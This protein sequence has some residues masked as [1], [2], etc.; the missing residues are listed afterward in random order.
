MEKLLNVVE[1]PEDSA[2]IILIH[3]GPC[4]GK[5]AFATRFGY[6]MLNNGY[7]YIIWMDLREGYL[8]SDDINGPPSEEKL[9]I[10]ILDEF[11]M[12]CPDKAG[13]AKKQLKSK[14]RSIKENGKRV[15]V[16][17]DNADVLIENQRPETSQDAY[18][19]IKEIAS[20]STKFVLTSRSSNVM[21]VT[22]VEIKNLTDEES[23]MYVD[24]SLSKETL[25]DRDTL[26]QR[27]TKYSK[28]MPFAL[29]IL[30]YEVKSA[31]DRDYLEEYLDDV[32]RQPLQTLDDQVHPIMRLFETS[33]KHLTNEELQ[34]MK[35]LAVFPGSFSY[36]YVQKLSQHFGSKATIIKN[37]RQKGLLESYNENF[38]IHPLLQEFSRKFFRWN[39]EKKEEKDE[40]Q[41]GFIKVYVESLFLLGWESLEKD[42]F[43][44]CLTE[45]RKEKNNFLYL[46]E[47]LKQDWIMKKEWEIFN[48][49]S[50]DYI[51][52]M[53]FIA[54]LMYAHTL[55]NFFKSCEILASKEY[56]Y[57]A[58]SCQFE[59]CK[60][61]LETSIKKNDEFDNVDLDVD[62]Y[63]S[64]LLER[65][66]LADE[67]HLKRSSK[68]QNYLIGQL[69]GFVDK[70]KQ[71]PNKKIAS[72]FQHKACKLLGNIHK[73][74]SKKNEA[75]YFFEEAL[76]ICNN[77]V[78]Q[79]IH[80][81]DC[82]IQLA[83]FHWRFNEYGKANE[84]FD[85]AND[86]A[87]K[88]KISDSKIYSSY[89]L[90]HGR[91]LIDS[92]KPENVEKGVILLKK[93]LKSCDNT[94][95]MF[96]C[97]A[98]EYLLR[99][100]SRHS[101]KV[102]PYLYTLESPGF[103]ILQLV[104]KCFENDAKEL[105]KASCFVAKVYERNPRWCPESFHQLKALLT[106]NQLSKK[107]LGDTVA[108]ADHDET[109]LA[110]F[111]EKALNLCGEER[112][113][114]L[115][116][117]CQFYPR[118]Y[119][120]VLPELKSKEQVDDQL[121]TIVTD[122][123]VFENG[124]PEREFDEEKVE[125]M[126]R[127]SIKDMREAINYVQDIYVNSPENTNRN[128]VQPLF[129]WNKLLA[130][131]TTHI[132]LEIRER[133]KYAEAALIWKRHGA[134]EMKQR[135]LKQLEELA[136]DIRSVSSQREKRLQRL[137]A[138]EN[139]LRRMSKNMIKRGQR[140]ELENRFLK[141]F[142]DSGGFIDIRLRII[143][144][145]LN[146]LKVA[147]EKY[148]QYF[149]KL[150]QVIESANEG[151][152]E[153]HYKILVDHLP[154]LFSRSA[155]DGNHR[156]PGAEIGQKALTLL[157]IRKNT[158][159]GNYK[160]DRLKFEIMYIMA[161]QAEGKMDVEERKRIA[162]SAF[163]LF[164]SRKK[165]ERMTEKHNELRHFIDTL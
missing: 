53:L 133:A 100:D 88:I 128:L 150:L 27:I 35:V 65:R 32:E 72:Y 87:E 147:V 114:I 80:T 117:L 144:Y 15:L 13:Q 6:E 153:W 9:A 22:K 47:L 25:M 31:D 101:D 108:E 94:H 135:E 39:K 126:T 82:Y 142:E 102:I 61:L 158:L 20:P 162:L 157:E 119:D 121:L 97:R 57:R 41:A 73:K 14:F 34:L 43:A 156:H 141:L 155:F 77:S 18:R 116:L 123:F 42:H 79:H 138:R 122:K 148:P 48:R 19:M 49:E 105:A 11:G 4:Y 93:S 64:I 86:L 104:T 52:M 56:R 149:E 164:Q 160:T 107:L 165:D 103:N 10:R 146:H 69:Q 63:C 110:D 91:C 136:Q 78:G 30:T 84:N 152:H 12:D 137:S 17:L 16:I 51:A 130:T 83:K 145:V 28:G 106:W 113:S 50:E 99:V 74:K 7:N 96:F 33:F 70:V 143:Q 127:K 90:G 85:K 23:K 132:Y 140:D 81:Y 5:S 37:I 55:I 40:Y 21:D 129:I 151:I 154:T 36:K 111:A 45:F 26:I 1:E 46:M 44:E 89:L 71:L 60:K 95:S 112:A 161:L 120:L 24:A 8:V 2:N 29:K 163:V 131:R 134:S 59:L 3:G 68:E 58:W 75:N 54:D 67:V 98:L 62:D 118:Y 159:F 124:A 115:K 66:Q 38:H 125:I 76:K 139:L 92:N 109:R